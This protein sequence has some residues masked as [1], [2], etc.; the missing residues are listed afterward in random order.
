VSALA[1]LV[2][3]LPGLA[4]WAWF[5]KQD[6]DPLVALA[7]ITGISLSVI[8]L[9]AEIVFL[10]NGRFS[11]WIIIF[12]AV[13]FAGLAV[14]GWILH[15]IHWSGKFRRYLLIGLPVLGL[16]IAWRLFQARGFLLPNWVDSQHHYLIVRTILENGGLPDTMAPYLE[17]P[18]YYHY[19][20]HAVA[21]LYTTISGLEIGQSM[22]VVGQVLN[23]LIG[24]S[25]YALGKAL[26]KDWRPAALAALM[27]S[28]VTRMP[29]YYLSWGRYT[30]TMGMVFLPLAIGM[31]LRLIHKPRRKADI[32]LMALLTAGVLLSHYF[33]ALLLAIYLII[34]A[35]VHF[36]PRLRR[37]LTALA[38]L[39]G[40]ISGAGLGSLLALPWLL[41]VAHYSALSTGISSNFAALT[42]GSGNAAY[43]WKLL[44]PL[45]NQI[46]LIPAIIGLVIALVKLKQSAFAIW[47]LFLAILALPWSINL[48]PFRA[49]HFAIVLFLPVTLWAGWLFWQTGRRVAR[50]SHKR[51]VC[52]NL[53][54]VVLAGW[55]IWSYPLSSDIVNPVTVMVTEDDLDALAWVKANTPEDARFFIN[56]TYWQNDIY[57]G[58]DGGGWLLPYTGRWALVPTVFYGFSPDEEMKLQIRAWGEDAAKVTTCSPEFWTLAEETNVDW[59]YIREGVGGMQPEEIMECQGVETIFKNESV[60]ILKILD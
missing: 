41:R 47:S 34:L 29:A 35:F 19:G 50:F 45:S 7:Q 53:L 2:L 44:G 46:L 37:M 26:W 14:V 56:T 10:L 31:A 36:L 39:S 8:I 52:A 5:G 4:W 3:L 55:M 24:L 20:F 11:G 16:V 43:I 60:T 33:A 32:A 12:L 15:G 40:I 22:L 25:I 57:R 42:N 51:W 48:R 23:G 38:G 30:L 1:F 9:L 54:L 27:V 58:V 13:L 18:F 21:A 59:I 49:D 28:F 6:R 17:M